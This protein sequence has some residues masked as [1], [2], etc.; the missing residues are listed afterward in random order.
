V[1]RI[2]DVYSG[3]EFFHPGS[4]VKKISDPGSESASK[5][6][7]P[8]T[9]SKLSEK[10]SG[11][12]VPDPDFF[13]RIL[14]LGIKKHRIPDPNTGC[15][16]GSDPDSMGSLNP[17]SQSGSESRRAKVAHKNREKLINFIF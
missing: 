9:V 10:L 8:K 17:D 11:L 15:G 16:S 5:N 13:P 2:R 7:R 1:L 6:F 12:F 14:D 3:S 4:R